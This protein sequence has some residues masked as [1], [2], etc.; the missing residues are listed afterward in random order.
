M[1]YRY[2]D[3][4]QSIEEDLLTTKRYVDFNSMN[5]SVYSIEFARIVLSSCAEIDM[6]FKEI[7]SKVSDQRCDNIKKYKEA[8]LLHDPDFRIRQRKV[9]YL[10]IDVK[11]FEQWNLQNG[12]NPEWWRSYNAIK[13]ERSS[14][15]HRAS[16]K[17]AIS[18]LAGLQIVLFEFYKLDNNDPFVTFEFKDIPKL[19]LPKSVGSSLMKEGLFIKFSV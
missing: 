5:F 2:W 11:P 8:V 9:A 19:I 6:V 7:C 4:Y 13:H 17:N 16:L 1:S 18:S 12:D 14:S 10:G 3:Y 15:F